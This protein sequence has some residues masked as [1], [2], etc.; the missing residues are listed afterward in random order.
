[1]LQDNLG[2]EHLARSASLDSHHEDKYHE[3]GM[4]KNVAGRA[5]I[6]YGSTFLTRSGKLWLETQKQHGLRFENVAVL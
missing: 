2:Q 6:Q 5:K 4:T 3:H 1:M